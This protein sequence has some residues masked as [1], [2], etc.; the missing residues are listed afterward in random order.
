MDT[1]ACSKT[2]SLIVVYWGRVARLTV[3][4]AL[5]QVTVKTVV[6]SVVSV[7]D[8]VPEAA[9]VPDKAP[10]PVQATSSVLDHWTSTD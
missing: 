5:P 1:S 3:W 2:G 10:E 9:S 7:T 4:L 6:P 8:C